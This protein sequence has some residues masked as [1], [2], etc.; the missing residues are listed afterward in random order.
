V[1]SSSRDADVLVVGGGPGGST[2]ATFLAQGGLTVTVVEREAFPRFKVGESLIPTCMDICR[3]LGVLDRVLAHGF[4]MKYGATFHDQE[5]GLSSTFDF[6][7]GR[8]WPAFTLDVHRAEFDQIL[9]DHAAS[10]AGVTVEQPAT[11]EKV[12]FDADGVTARLSDAGGERELRAAF[13]VDA[14]GRDAFLAARQGQ[15]KPRPGLGKVA[16]FAYYRGARRFP[17]R[18]EGHVRIYIFPEGWFWYIPLARDETSV[19]CVLHQRVV[20]SRR[21]SLPELFEDMVERCRAVSD[22]LRGAAPVTE[23]YTTSNFAYSVDPIVGDRFVCVGD[24]V[25]FVDPIFS[26]GVFLAMQSGELAAGAIRRAFGARRFEARRF[27]AYERAVRRGT[28]PFER[29]IESFYDRAFLE[30]FLRPRNVLGMVPAVTGVLAG[31]SFGTLPRHLRLSLWGFHQV[32]RLTRWL[33][34]RRGVVLESRLD[35]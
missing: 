20:K 13:L 4:Q 29:F 24:A 22:N 11:V 12:A 34:R 7:P 35:W 8:P 3:R 19:G 16:L 15:R 9:L 30:V 5:L 33:N 18:E 31:G 10:H 14:S 6:R 32:V 17:G 21:G 26:P 23:L 28:R 25:A 1:T 27:R 2:V